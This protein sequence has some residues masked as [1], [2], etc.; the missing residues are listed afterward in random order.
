VGKADPRHRP[1]LPVG[2]AF[3][4]ALLA[5]ATPAA[6]QDAARDKDGRDPGEIVV[7]GLPGQAVDPARLPPAS[8][9]LG[10]EDLRRGGTVSMLRALG[11]D[12][13][14]VILDDAQDNPYQPNLLYRGYEASPL[15]GDAQGLAVY[16]DGARFNQPFGDTANW[17]LIPDIAVARLTLEGSSP[18]FG[19]NALGGALA[20]ELKSGRD[21][22]G[23]GGEAAI[24]RFGKRQVAAEAGG[25]DGALSFYLAGAV[26]HD[27]GWRD[28]SPSTVRQLYAQI[29]ADGPWGKVDL[30]L[31]GADTDLTGNGTAPVEL[32]AARRA[33][34]FTWP[35][36][37]RNR[38]GRALLAADLA[39][40]DHL[41]LKPGA[42]V[43]RFRQR[44][45]NGDL[46]DARAC[47]GDASILCLEGNDGEIVTGASGTPFPAFD[48][49]DGYGQLNATSTRTT[50][51][52][53]ALELDED[54]P[55]GAM[56]NRLA[57]GIAYD[58]SH[59]R[60]EAGSTLGILTADRGFGDPRGVIDIAGGP[61]VPVDVATRRTDLGFY[62]TDMVTVLP[63]FDLTLAARYEDS[64]VAL[65][66]RLGT[67]LSGRHDYRRLNPSVG[68]AWR[69]GGGVSLY[70]GYAEANRAPTPAEL[71]CADPAA[72]CA[73]S[74]FFVADPDLK[75]V[76]SRTFEAGIRGRR[77]SGPV[78]IAW[79]IGGWRSAVS[80]D[81]VFAASATRGRAFFRNVG[82]TRRQ[83]IESELSVAGG[84]WSGRLSYVLTDATY[85]SAF[86]L[87]SPDNPAADADGLIAVVPGDRIPGIPRHRAKASVTWR[88]GTRAWVSI[89]GQV[90]SG[91]WLLGDEANLTRPTASYWLTDLSAGF[92]P[93]AE[94]ELFGEI[95]NLFDRKYATFGAFAETSAVAF[96]EA[97]GIAD[98]RALSPGAP[99]T[100]LVGARL[101]F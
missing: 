12:A 36:Q 93:A 3:G 15:G 100:W 86:P 1:R 5:L 73:L 71:S 64:H 46:S 14:G 41:R 39:L 17:D 98:P 70:G 92:R 59:S 53:A 22:Q 88:F 2:W 90:S 44:T 49:N 66:D 80:N 19:L 42:Y 10:A 55:L 11:N 60:F 25:H 83:G 31:I 97:P 33:S 62:A 87:A 84:P 32:L 101:H 24:G 96:A 95:D 26:Q 63:G 45:A 81:I 23:A 91:R 89:D 30:R 8:D 20:V 4:L 67:A 40:G 48:G 68:A 85:R 74:A 51:Y 54:S 77:E 27:D 28:F 82:G 99:R 35:D 78:T 34:V 69:A 94:V 76:V 79:R 61:I 56:R 58:G 75:Q 43:E 16:V 21:F 37:T 38:Y 52:G 18:L 6:A 9:R 50:G 29:G 57:A 7:T 13:P 47:D 72:P 65:D